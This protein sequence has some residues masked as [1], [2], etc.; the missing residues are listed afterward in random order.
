MLVAWLA[1]FLVGLAL[2]VDDASTDDGFRAASCKVL[3]EGSSRTFDDALVNC[4]QDELRS[5]PACS[6]DMTHP[7][8]EG[9][10]EYPGP[11]LCERTAAFCF[12]QQNT[13]TNA[14]DCEDRQYC[15]KPLEIPL[16]ER[17]AR[18]E[19]AEVPKRH[20]CP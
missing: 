15:Y 1:L 7:S 10:S 2:Y 16:E 6:C 17:P 19:Q 20:V 9:I 11:F 18:C 13:P 3:A 5:A 12:T 4:Y 8:E 14:V